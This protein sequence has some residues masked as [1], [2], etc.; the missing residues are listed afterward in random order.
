[1]VFNDSKRSS[2]KG[3]CAH[4][5]R[6]NTSPAWCQT[7]DPQRTTQGWTSGNKNI[8]DYIKEF[9]HK[10]TEYEN[11]IEWIPFNRLDII[12]KN[13][14]VLA[15]WLDGIRIIFG[16]QSEYTQSRTQQCII[17]L[18]TLPNSHD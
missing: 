6:Y 7:C 4:C 12:Q 3:K 15:I 5:N 16:C 1:L 8:D 14:E 2:R 13:G 11:V 9:Q 17:T 10:T 18:K